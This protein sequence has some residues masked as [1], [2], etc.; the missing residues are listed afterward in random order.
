MQKY[1]KNPATERQ[2]K[3]KFIL[4]FTYDNQNGS[5]R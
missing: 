4:I 2:S 3:Y 1:F 5:A